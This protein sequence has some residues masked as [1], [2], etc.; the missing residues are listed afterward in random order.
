[1]QEELRRLTHRAH[2]QEEAD[3]GQRIDVEAQEVEALADQAGR[4]GENR[5][6]GDRAGQQENREN[7][8]RE[9]E[10]ADPVDEEGLDRRGVSFRFVEPET[11]EQI[12]RDAHPFPAEEQLRQIVGRH[13]HQHGEGEERQIRE[14]PRLVRIVRHVADRIEVDET[15]NGRHHDQ[16]HRGERVDAQR[17]I[18]FEIA[19][20]DE[21]ED[22]DVSVVPGKADIVERVAGQQPRDGKQRRGDQLGHLRAGARRPAPVRLVARMIDFGVCGVQRQRAVSVALRH[23]RGGVIVV[24]RRRVLAGQAIARADQRNHAGDNGAQK[25]QENDRKIHF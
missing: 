1:M 24:R 7:T 19:R 17:P 8:K 25:R 18:D 5:I 13:Q 9:A 10:I 2:K 22:C 3:Q 12:A 14:E 6:E 20:G 23:E 4:L 15:R 21:I 16:H 11:D